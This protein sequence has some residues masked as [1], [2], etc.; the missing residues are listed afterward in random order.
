[1]SVAG[2]GPALGDTLYLSTQTTILVVDT[3]TGA[4]LNEWNQQYGVEDITVSDSIRTIGPKTGDSGAEYT[5]AGVATGVT[6][7]NPMPVD[8]G[9]HASLAMGGGTSDGTHNYIFDYFSGTV[10]ETT[11]DFTNPVALFGAGGTAVVSDISYDREN[12]SLWI[13]YGD[14]SHVYDYDLSGHVLSEIPTSN[15]A[16]G[17]GMVAFDPLDDTLWVDTTLGL[18]HFT[19]TGTLLGSINRPDAI[20]RGGEFAEPV[21][22]PSALVLLAAGILGLAGLRARQAVA[23]RV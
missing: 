5:L 13:A 16:T 17:N 15:I 3:S 7:T 23:G 10:F 6:Y 2:V 14:G 20:L 11:L 1:M 9:T 22:E 19:T 18:Q 8:I 4:I 12:G 21:P